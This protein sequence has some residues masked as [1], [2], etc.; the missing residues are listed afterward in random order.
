M[1]LAAAGAQLNRGAQ[2]SRP[3]NRSDLQYHDLTLALDATTRSE[4][5]VPAHTPMVMMNA[6]PTQTVLMHAA[7]FPA[8][9]TVT[10]PESAPGWRRE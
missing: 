7:A 4:A 9:P 8:L 6:L 10:E 3:L 5:L 2:L 1:R